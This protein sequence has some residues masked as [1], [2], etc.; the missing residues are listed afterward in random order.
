MSAATVPTVR[1]SGAPEERGAQLGRQA[2]AQIHKSM[3][4]YR[5]AFAH[6]TGLTWAEVRKRALAFQPA[7]EAYDDEI[8]PEMAG[9]AAGAGLDFE[10][11]LAI[12]TRTEV[13]YGVSAQ[14][15][16]E[17]TA[18]GARRSATHDGNVLLGQ[19]WDWLAPSR[20]SCILLEADLPGRPSFVT[21]VE[22]GLL[23][24]IGFNDAGIGLVTNLL[25]TDEDRGEPGVPFHVILRGVLTAS[26]FAEAIEAVTR[27]PRASSANFLIAGADGEMVDLEVR[28]GGPDNVHRLEAVDDR[29]HHTNAFCGPI[30]SAQDRGLAVL[31]DSVPRNDRIGALLEAR[32]GGLDVDSAMEALR[33]HEGLPAAICRH[34][35]DDVHPMER[36]ETIGSV[37][38]DLAAARM[39]LA[40][41]PPCEHEYVT[42]TPQVAQGPGA[43]GR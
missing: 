18:F 15:A 22:A 35:D 13:M 1:I 19:N 32:H 10:D 2:S 42:V 29:V 34:P 38:I 8:V 3:A 43:P 41:G 23:A 24:K 20:D 16:P 27:A 26:S 21:F 33:D 17:C 12:N 6:Y 4:L 31:P 11:I 37:V 28:P 30:G 39:H 7:I 36:V 14:M 25:L 40:L 9:T 5:D